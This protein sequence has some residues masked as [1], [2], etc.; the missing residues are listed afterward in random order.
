V[1]HGTAYNIAGTGKADEASM[2]EA[3]LLGARLARQNIKRRR[4]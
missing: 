2:R 3:I 1:D 4:Q